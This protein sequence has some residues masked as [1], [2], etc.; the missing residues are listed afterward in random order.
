[1]P[2]P[3]KT[4]FLSYAH[5][6]RKWAND[7]TTFLAPWIRDKRVDFWD[8]SRI[9]PGEHWHDQID[10]ALDEATVAV[11]LVT[12]NFLASNFVM[13]HEL[14]ALL[15]RVKKGEVRLVWVA[16]EHSGVAATELA[17]FQAAN[18]P[19]R[20]LEVLSKPQRNAAMAH[21]AKA[22]ADAVTL[23]TFAGGLQIIDETTEPIE[24]AV[25]RRPERVQRQF[26]VQAQYDP[27]QD[28]ISFTGTATTITFADLAKLPDDDREFI[29][30]LEDSL[31]RN[32]QRWS[33]VRKGLGDAG[34]A[35][36][37]EVEH[38]MTRITKLIC[39][40]LNSI[41]DFLKKMYK[42]DLEDHYGRYRFI[43]SQLK[44]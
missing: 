2:E 17:N 18:D 20:P 19:G 6:D 28:K 37:T 23:G 16:A 30:D 33:S 21:I 44:S 3:R 14:P 13:N 4:V 22:I 34:G 11:L 1:M 40:D 35:L 25:E 26:R 29:A 15:K 8:D 31:K 7:L 24:A 27:A 9:Q 36:D 12:K 42:Y 5:E 43:C 39:V 41:L 38:Q 32:Y 10:R